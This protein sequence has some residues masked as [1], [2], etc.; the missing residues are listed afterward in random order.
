MNPKDINDKRSIKDFNGMTFSG[1]KKS[2]AKRIT[3]SS[4][5]WKN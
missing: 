2:E 3:K 4:L 5:S 1:Y